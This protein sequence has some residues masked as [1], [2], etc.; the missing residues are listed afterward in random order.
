MPEPLDLLA[1]VAHPDDAELLCGGSL[2]RAADAGRRTGVLDL[3]G[4]EA[5][6]RGSAA[7]R[8]DEA[9]K[10]AEIL[11]LATRRVAGLPDGALENTPAARNAV[12]AVL[13]ELRP[14]TVILMWHE[15]RHP[16]HR[17]ASQLAYDACFVAGLSKAPVDGERFRPRKV[18]YA[19]AYREH[20]PKPSFVVDISDQMERK[21]DA[22]YAYGSQFEGKKGMG[23]IYPGGDRALRD[24][25]LVHH[26]YYGGLIRTAYGEPFWTRETL[27]VDDVTALDVASF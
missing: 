10:A 27:R 9:A 20:V 22:I 25:L 6:T 17:I 24:Q 18:V 7:L 16:D 5:G 1:I 11:G 13:R 23:E 8:E 19:M 26:A 15:A 12:A 3:T 2:I 14:D 21:L 4:G